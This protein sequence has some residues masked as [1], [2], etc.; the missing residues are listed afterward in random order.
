MKITRDLMFESYLINWIKDREAG[1]RKG[2]HQSD[3]LFCLN[4]SALRRLKPIE[5][6]KEELLRWGRGYAVQRWLTRKLE[7]VPTIEVDGIQVTLDALTC[8]KCGGVFN[9]LSS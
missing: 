2:T 5:P 6:T 7:D 1:D 8:P 4:E 3:L 9:E